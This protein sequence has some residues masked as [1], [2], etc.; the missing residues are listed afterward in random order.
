MARQHPDRHH[1][2][3][4]HHEADDEAHCGNPLHAMEG[5]RDGQPNVGI[6]A[7]SALVLRGKGNR[8]NWQK[9]RNKPEQHACRHGS[10]CNAEHGRGGRP[11]DMRLDQAAEQQRRK[12]DVVDQ[13]LQPVPEVITQMQYPAQSC[14]ENNQGKV[15]KKSKG[16]GGFDMHCP[17]RLPWPRAVLQS[18]LRKSPLRQE[19]NRYRHRQRGPVCGWSRARR[20]A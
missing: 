18:A 1:I 8:R 3:R 14:A 17:P 15:G 7:E 13:F 10:C 19:P 9:A 20:K 11:V 4:W 2:G 16:D 6:E 5:S 12:Q